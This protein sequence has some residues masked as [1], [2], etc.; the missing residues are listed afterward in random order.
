MYSLFKLLDDSYFTTP[1]YDRDENGNIVVEVE[2]PGF[3]KDNLNVEIVDGYI[4]IHGETD[5]RTYQKHFAIRNIED[6]N[7]SIKDGIL[8]LTLIEQ[9]K[10]VKKIALNTK[11]IEDQTD[12][13]IDAVS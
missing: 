12:N 5:K 7:A 4:N 13:I 3:N 2:V 6:V 1:D 9:N 8:S 11:Q 10:Q